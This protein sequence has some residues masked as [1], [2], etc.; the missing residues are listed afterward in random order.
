MLN[1]EDQYEI[2]KF[3]AYFCSAMHFFKKRKNLIPGQVLKVSKK[4][5]GKREN[6]IRYYVHKYFGIQIGKYSYGYRQFFTKQDIL[7]SV[8]AFCSISGFVVIANGNHPMD[9]VTTHPITYNPEYRMVNRYHDEY[10]TGS[11]VTIGNDVWIG[12]S[13][14][15]LPGVKIG[16]GAVIAAGAVVTKDVPDYAV[17]IGVPA[18]IHKYRFSDEIIQALLRIKWWEWPDEKIKENIHLLSSPQEFVSKFD[19]P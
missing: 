14:T 13:V 7:K 10:F 6:L 4:K 17:V 16:N 1:L 15:I 3:D 11:E 5:Y 9:F 18:K 2:S 8:G 19:N 12:A